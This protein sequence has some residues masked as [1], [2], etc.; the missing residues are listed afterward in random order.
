LSKK[1][2]DLLI[3]ESE[4]SLDFTDYEIDFIVEEIEEIETVTRSG[5]SVKMNHIFKDDFVSS[6]EES[7]IFKKKKT[8]KKLTPYLHTSLFHIGQLLRFFKG[9]YK[10]F[11]GAQKIE[12]KIKKLKFIYERKTNKRKNFHLQTL[13][14][15]II[16]TEVLNG[17]EEIFST[18]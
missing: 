5:R 7:K 14:G 3:V 8:T 15:E 16:T 10:L 18:N 4:T 9:N 2:F 12:L 17:A 11:N 13:K 1:D 6:I